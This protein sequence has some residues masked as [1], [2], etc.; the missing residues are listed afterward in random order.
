VNIVF[1]SPREGLLPNAI[2]LL[3]HKLTQLEGTL[4]ELPMRV[5]ACRP[6]LLLLAGLEPGDALL[7]VIETINAA[8]P[9]TAI[10]LICSTPEPGFL[11]RAMRAGIREVISSDAPA[12]IA[13]VIGRAQSRLHVTRASQAPPGRCIGFMPATGGDGC[14]CVMANLGAEIAK[15]PGLR[16]LLIDLSLPFGNVE[17]FLTNESAAH[18]LADFSDEIERLDG[19]LL[20]VMTHHLAPNMHLIHAPESL[21]QLLHVT[22]A[23]VE[24]LIRIA[25][26]H[27]DYLLIDMGLDAISLRVL[28]LLDQLV[29]VSTASL[30]SVRRAS[31]ITRLWESLGYAAAKLS[32]VVNRMGNSPQVQL[33]DIEKAVGLKVS[34][35]L[36]EESDQM[37]ESLLK[38]VATILLKP[39]SGFAKAI[40]AM[41]A[42]LTGQPVTEKSIWHRLGIK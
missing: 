37:E 22:P 6:D 3:E 21:S 35:V 20:E 7:E 8:L 27:Y 10:V 36:P 42:Q 34:R 33:G 24:R 40:A 25:L 13:S 17:L 38:G 39:R 11:M 16:V 26:H 5:L 12:V 9:A 32:L 28:E 29:V 15:S 23:Y 1:F 18:D 19:A 2:D 30:P 4:A 14:T 31:Q 41:A